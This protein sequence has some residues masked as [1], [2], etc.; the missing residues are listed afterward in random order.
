MPIVLFSLTISACWE[1][2][3]VEQRFVFETACN[4]RLAAQV[5]CC[6]AAPERACLPSRASR[7]APRRAPRC[8]WPRTPRE[9][10]CAVPHSSHGDR[11]R[12]ARGARNDEAQRKPPPNKAPH[13]AP[14]QAPEGANKPPPWTG[15]WKDEAPPDGERP[16]GP[17]EVRVLFLGRHD[18]RRGPHALHGAV[19]GADAERQQRPRVAGSRV[20]AARS[21]RDGRHRRGRLADAARRDG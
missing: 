18:L 2:E 7:R 15:W 19:D 17:R 8:V 12:A 4:H 16:V 10:R 21:H 13:K 14:N 11:W 1:L 20:A 3:S 5:R 9:L 6:R